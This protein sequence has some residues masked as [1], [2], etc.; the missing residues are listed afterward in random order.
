VKP[1]VAALFLALAGTLPLAAQE[2]IPPAN[3]VMP[4][5]YLQAMPA[6]DRVLSDM[7]VADSVETRARQHAAVFYL[8]EILDVLTSDHMYVRTSD[9]KVRSGADS[10]GNQP[11]SGI[12][13]RRE[14]P[15][16]RLSRGSRPD[17]LDQPVL[18]QEHSVPQ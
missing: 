9:N 8:R 7:K 10:G 11:Q 6:V 2:R 18:C 17:G 16:L 12:P 3:S 5:G 13:R 4:P 1:K 14:P 15:V